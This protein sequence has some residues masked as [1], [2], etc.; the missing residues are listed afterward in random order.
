VRSLPRSL[1]LAGVSLL[2]VTTATRA[3]VQ[4]KLA[5]GQ[6]TLDAR[7]ASIQEILA[8]IKEQTGMTVIYDGVPPSQRLEM[9]LSSVTPV[10]AVLK[11]LEG[12]GLK[13]AMV[14]DPTGARV[15][16]LLISTVPTTVRAAAP[17]AFDENEGMYPMPEYVTEEP[18]VPEM[19]P[20][21]MGGHPEN[22]GLPSEAQPAPTPYVP[23][24]PPPPPASPFTPQGQGPII[25]PLPGATPAPTAA[26]PP[27]PQEY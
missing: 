20:G 5:E 9:S 16:T 1:V 14:T 17:A 15:E 22:P 11:V 6:L 25:L 19:P 2:S 26:T 10:T 13:F 24:T 21:T 12:R 7:G 3:D 23:P 18:P 8:Q 4:V 27:P